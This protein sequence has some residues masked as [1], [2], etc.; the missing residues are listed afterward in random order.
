MTM[1][2]E[3]T[4]AVEY[5]RRFLEALMDSKRTP[6]VPLDIRLQARACLKHYPTEYDMKRPESFSWAEEKKLWKEV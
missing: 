3:R 2:Y 5:T 6:R 4:L 1:P